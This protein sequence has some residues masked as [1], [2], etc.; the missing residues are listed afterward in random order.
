[1]L[2]LT[3]HA[4]AS[5]QDIFGHGA[6]TSALGATG[7]ASALGPEAV[8][9]NPAL[10][11]LGRERTF[12]LG[13]QGALMH[14]SAQGDGLP[15]A[16]DGEPMRGT[17]IGALLPLP[18][19]GA[20]QHRIA[21]GF[22]FF[23]PT[24]VVVRGR[25]L[26]P[27]TP[28]FPLVTDRAQSVT[29]Q[30]GFG[31]DLGKGIRLGAGLSA[32]AAIAGTVIVA[33]DTSGAVG[34][35]VDD[36]LVATYAP[37]TGFTYDL[38]DSYRL[39]IT[40]RGQLE[41][42]FA[43]RIE[44]Y[45]LGSLTVPPFNI[46][47]LAQFD[48]WQVQAEVAR[49]RGPWKTAVGVTFKRWSSYPGAPEP[50]VLCPPEKPNCQAL[51]PEPPGFHDTAVPRV[52]VERTVVDREGWGATARAGYFLEPSPTPEQRGTERIFDNTRHALTLGGGLEL[53]GSIPLSLD[54]FA[55]G[56]WLAK[57]SHRILVDA[58]TGRTGKAT[59]GGYLLAGGVV[60]SVRF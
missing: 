17:L 2:L 60:A 32:L 4:Q 35:K 5:P 8:W 52:G 14:L 26:Y 57:R 30:A 29:V 38:S 55:Q 23:T 59:A 39:G 51:K 7:A 33:T 40:Y 54:L 19:S 47:G 10:L 45:D 58:G 6:R 16:L 43:V 11:S 28:Q 21:L 49:V 13:V 12:S 22:S 34:T 48:P 24:N 37:L 27:E 46:A 53:R 15:G 3:A 50:T 18:F 25:V 41:A 56:H 36:Q 20:L 42:R 1:M 9:G 44:V 31:F